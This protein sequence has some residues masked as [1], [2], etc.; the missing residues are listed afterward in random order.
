[1]DWGDTVF[2]TE[3]DAP[4]EAESTLVFIRDVTISGITDVETYSGFSLSWSDEICDANAA[5]G[6]TDFGP[7][8]KGHSQDDCVLGCAANDDC[9][10]VSITAVGW[11]R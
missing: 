11:C 2:R 10:F 4:T 5:I 7:G 8:G 3:C 9:L 1:V 6:A